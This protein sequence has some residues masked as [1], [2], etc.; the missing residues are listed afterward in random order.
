MKEKGRMKDILTPVQTV[1]S[2]KRNL[3][4]CK[5]ISAEKFRDFCREVEK[6]LQRSRATSL[7]VLC[8]FFCCYTK[9]SSKMIS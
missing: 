7:Q 1:L 3:L 8:G 4:K 9:Q 2:W 6:V 5:K